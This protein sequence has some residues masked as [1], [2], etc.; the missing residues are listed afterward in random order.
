MTTNNLANRRNWCLIMISFVGILCLLVTQ[1]YGR[2]IKGVASAAAVQGYRLISAWLLVIGWSMA[3]VTVAWVLRRW[4]RAGAGIEGVEPKK[5]ESVTPT[6]RGGALEC[7]I[8]FALVFLAYCP[9]FLARSGPFVEDHIFLGVLHRIEAGQQPYRDF[10]FLYGPLMY[11]IADA[12]SRI[13]GYSML[14]YYWLIAILQASQVALL[15]AV[16]RRFIPDRRQRYLALALFLPFVV[17]TLLGLNWIGW[18]RLLPIF[19]MLLI[20]LDGP[21]RRRLFGAVLLGVSMSYSQEQGLAAVIAVTGVEF[22]L[23]KGWRRIRRAATTILVVMTTWGIIAVAITQDDFL[24]YL[25]STTVLATRFAMG[26]AG[27]PFGWTLNSIALFIL[28]SICLVILGR[29]GGRSRDQTPG[30][31]DRFFVAALLFFLVVIQS[32]LNR[33]DLWHLNAAFLPLILAWL[34]PL[35]TA[36][37][38]LGGWARR[39]AKL[40]IMVAALTYLAGLLPSGSYVVRGWFAGLEDTVS[41]GTENDHRDVVTRGHALEL[42]RAHPDPDVVGLAVYLGSPERRDRPVY[43]YGNRWSLGKQIG[44]AKRDFLNDDF[45]YDEIRGRQLAKKISSDIDSLVVMHEIDYDRLFGELPIDS[46]PEYELFHPPSTAKR[47]LGF[48]S[49][50]HWRELRTEMR[51]KNAR[52]RRTVGEMLTRTMR[53]E[54]VFGRNVVLSR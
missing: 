45:I 19:G 50:V 46:I 23:G 28:A 36:I 51:M 38:G 7:G 35:P 22:L 39:T 34:L 41:A 8:A 27:F 54:A 5:P 16:F 3:V 1:P 9:V 6:A 20:A 10:E 11:W 37:F 15:T 33:C 43:F 30:A 13:F 4:L 14:A 47:V 24:I 2:Q 31:G 17:D 44:V 53:R 32:G 42:E 25:E 26:E 21:G 52:W 18:R 48:L 29:D 12:W 49:S 40:V